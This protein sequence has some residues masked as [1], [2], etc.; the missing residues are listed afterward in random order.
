MTQSPMYLSNFWVYRNEDLILPV[1]TTLVLISVLFVFNII[2]GYWFE[3]RKNRAMAN[4]FGE[5][6]APELVNVM[7]EDPENYSMEGEKRELTIL[8]VDVRDFTSISEALEANS[9]REYINLYLTAMSNNVYD[10]RGTLDKYIGDCVMA[11]WG[12]PLY[13]PEHASHAVTTALVMLQTIKDLNS[14]FKIRNLPL[15]KIGIGINTGEVRV[16]DMGSKIRRAYTVMGDPVNVASRLEG[17]TKE[18]GVEIIVGEVTK[19]SSPEFAYRELDRVRVKGKQEPVAIFEP[20]GLRSAIDDATFIQLKKWHQALALY[21]KQKWDQAAAIV[22]ELQK[23]DPGRWLYQ[24]TLNNIELHRH[25]AL[26]TDWD[27]VATY[28]TK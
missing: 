16:G 5:Y 25:L 22:T 12:A 24:H 11:F 19:N 10:N 7:A 23:S 17:L 27:G 8:F 13:L 15:L 4:L 20:I 18:Y 1:A 6:V 21:R 26:A 9:L 2:W 3:F 28:T 14:D